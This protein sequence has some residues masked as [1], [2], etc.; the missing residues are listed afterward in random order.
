MFDGNPGEGWRSRWYGSRTF[1]GDKNGVGVLLDL[2]SPTVVKEVEL[3]LGAEQDVT[4]YAT[5]SGSTESLDG[6]QEIGSATN[7][8]GTVTIKAGG[9]LNPAS[10]IVVLVTKAGRAE[11]D[12]RY[13]AQINEVTVR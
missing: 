3:V 6:A 1:N 13:R 5:S 10:K 8:N 4:V 2:S 9:Q 12:R 11:S 7:A